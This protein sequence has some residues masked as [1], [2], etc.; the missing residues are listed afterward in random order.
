MSWGGDINRRSISAGRHHEDACFNKGVEL[1]QNI[2]G[3][4]LWSEWKQRSSCRAVPVA[5]HSGAIAS[6]ITGIVI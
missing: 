3:I 1:T 5:N 6:A 2:P 4:V